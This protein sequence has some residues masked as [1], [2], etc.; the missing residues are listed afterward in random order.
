MREYKSWLYLPIEV[1]VR[2]LDA[3]L[4]LAYHAARK[5][6]LVVIGD[7]YMV[8]NASDQLPEGIFFSKGYPHG[9]RKRVITRASQNGHRIVEL[10]EEGLLIQA[11]RYIQDRMKRDMLKLIDKELCWGEFQHDVISKAYPDLASKCHIVGNPRFDLLTPRYRQ[12][13]EP[14]VQVLKEKHKEFILI[15]TRFSLYNTPRG[16]VDSP[17]FK[18]IKQ[19]YYYFIDLVKD[20]SER[21]PNETFIIRPHPGEDMQSYRKSFSTANN[22]KV[23]HEGNIIKWLLATK[24]IIHNGCTSAIEG[25]YLNKPVISYLPVEST[26]KE[27]PNQLGERLRTV[28]EVSKVMKELNVKT[29]RVNSPKV[30]APYCRWKEGEYAYDIIIHHCNEI[31]I[32]AQDIPVRQKLIIDRGIMTKQKRKRRFSLTQQE[33]QDFFLKINQVENLN[34]NLDIEPIGQ[35]LFKIK[36]L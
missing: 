2:E 36:A 20:L 31:A 24:L 13:Y 19:L 22:V 14:D 27:V 8:E 17:H 5:G 35:N 4:L 11:D 34:S 12:L 33:I 28:D 6:Y 7:H 18:S 16:K 9:F 1:K 15:N 25:F 10:D 30:M 32:P 21:F 3:K 23:V 29:G 26:S